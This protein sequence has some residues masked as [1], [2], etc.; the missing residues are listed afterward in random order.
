MNYLANFFVGAFLCNSL[1]HLI[2]GLQGMPFQ[3]PF[4]KP[5][6]VGESSPLV[7]FLWGLFNLLMAFWL[8][9]LNPIAVG[10]EPDFLAAVGGFTL[11]GVHAA[12]HFGKVRKNQRV[13]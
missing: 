1:P 11:L 10:L 9:S 2:A 4:A 7:N 6:G 5:S 12:F 13:H 3:S 8:F